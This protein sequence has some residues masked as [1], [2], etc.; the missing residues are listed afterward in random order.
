MGFR[1]K[2]MLS[3][4]LLIVAIA[5]SFYLYMDHV[6]ETNLVEESRTSLLGQAK[7]ARLLVMSD[8]LKLPPQQLAET[9]GATIRERLTLIAP[10]GRVIGDSDVSGAK[11]GELQNHLDRPEVQAAL[12]TG[13]GVAMRYSE[14]LKTDML[15]VAMTYGSGR[16]DGFVR[17]AMPLSYLTNSSKALHRVVGIAVLLTTLAALILSYILSNLTSRPLRTM[18][19]A[20]ARIGRGESP[21]RMPVTTHDEVGELARVLNDMSE[22]IE[23]QMQRLSSEKQQLDTILRG[24]GEGVMVTSPDG[25]IALVNPAFRRLFS[26]AGDVEG[27]KLIEI[28][29]HPDLLAAFNALDAAEGEELIREITIQ[30]GEITLLTHWAPLTV[31]GKKS[32][33]VAVFHDISD[34]K[35]VENIRRDFVA[36]VSHELRTPVSVIKGYAETLLDGALQS[37]GDRAARFVEIILSHS[38]RL[39]A[40]INDI[41]TLSTLESKGLILDRHPLDISGTMRKTYMLL[42]ENAHKKDIRM[43][44]DI[45]AGLPRVLADQGRVEQVIVNLLDNAIKYTPPQGMVTLS[46]RPGDN[47]GFLKIAVADTGIGV[48]FKDLPRIFERFYRVDE[49]RSRDQGGTGLELAIAKHIVQLHGGEISVTNNEF[50]K[51][52]IFSF[53]LPIA[54][55]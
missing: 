30:P 9:V 55:A 27:K 12:A 38:E 6:L 14:T 42:E 18:A 20:A 2:L 1:L 25:T 16:T 22:R 50:G 8:H 13:T 48:P 46:V 33:V 52:S 21:V 19:A 29:R 37:D 17:L 3:Y 7:L 43:Q 40:L 51:G 32:G 45:P 26:L 49:A 11:L 28:S 10:D 24:M 36:N 53:T 4:L 34:M 41:L 31:D 15:Y 44:I 39:T 23:Q 47:P 5:G 35:Q 54:A